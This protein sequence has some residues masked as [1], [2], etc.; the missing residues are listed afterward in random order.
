MQIN[1]ALRLNGTHLPK[2]HFD[3]EKKRGS[4][5]ESWTDEDGTSQSMADS[6]QLLLVLLMVMMNCAL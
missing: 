1:A 2:L 6:L 5:G 3:W 4:Q